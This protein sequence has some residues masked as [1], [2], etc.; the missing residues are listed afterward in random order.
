MYRITKLELQNL[1]VYSY[2]TIEVNDIELRKPRYQKKFIC[3]SLENV[4]DIKQFE[5]FNYKVPFI[6]LVKHF[7]FRKDI[8]IIQKVSS[9]R[10]IANIED[11]FVFWTDLLKLKTDKEIKE[12]LNEILSLQ[13]NK[14][15]WLLN[16]RNNK[17]IPTI[18]FYRKLRYGK[19]VKPEDYHYRTIKLKK[20]MFIHSW[21]DAQMK[22]NELDFPETN[23]TN[24]K[25]TIQ[26]NE[27]SKVLT[28][29]FKQLRLIYNKE[30]EPVVGNSIAEIASFLKINFS[31]FENTKLSTI[32][33][34]LKGTDNPPKTSRRITIEREKPQ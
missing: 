9:D 11:D 25:I 20:S 23:L 14:S 28:H 27:D 29:I 13:N 17:V 22:K 24:Y 33:T 5:D 8:L 4:K 15:F 32:E 10:F 30:G 16:F 18:L 6:A 21:V 31:C 7:V 2:K 26:W 1:R 34:M 19:N 12:R 3:V